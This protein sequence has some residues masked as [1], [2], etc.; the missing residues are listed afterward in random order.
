[1]R[2]QKRM[3]FNRAER[4]GDAIAHEIA[5]IILEEVSDPRVRSCTITSVA[6]SKDLR[7][8]KV[9]YSTLESDDEKIKRIDLALEKAEGFFKRRIGEALRLRYTPSL[10]F[11]HDPSLERGAKMLALIN[12]VTAQDDADDTED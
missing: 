9:Y 12:E 1:M 8:A 6:M 5:R 4:V 3:P 11:F 10:R 7:H 2:H